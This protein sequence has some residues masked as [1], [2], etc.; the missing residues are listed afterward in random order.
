MKKMVKD[1]SFNSVID[2]GC[3]NGAASEFFTEN[4]KKVTACDYGRSVHF[5]DT[6]AE[7]VLSG[8]FNQMK[9]DQQY[10]AVWY[11]HVLEH[12]LDVQAFWLNINSIL[13][14]GGNGNCSAKNETEISGDHVSLWNPG[15][16][17]YRLVLAGFD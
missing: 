13:S 9:F 11:S 17:V 2:I 10:D 7:N 1:Y 4:G 3:G 15:L 8:D 16:L 12:Q 5:E 6:M 14:E